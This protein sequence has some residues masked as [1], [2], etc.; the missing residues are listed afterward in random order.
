MHSLN[1]DLP[2]PVDSLLEES[3]PYSPGSVLSGR[4]P[5]LEKWS[6]SWAPL[7]EI[8]SAE[9]FLQALRSR[10]ISSARGY[11]EKD[12]TLLTRLGIDKNI[13]IAS[14]DITNR[15][16]SELF[17]LIDIGVIDAIDIYE[18]VVK[19]GSE[20]TIIRYYRR[21]PGILTEDD[22][23]STLGRIPGFIKRAAFDISSMNEKPARTRKSRVK[24]ETV[25]RIV[26]SSPRMQALI[27]L[28]EVMN[29]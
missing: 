14:F 5:Y 10:N 16:V 6:K 26:E 21:F 27:A 17:V 28:H 8:L 25:K 4:S 12:P 19:C 1:K 3:P 20:K 23:V 9:P 15:T 29:S 2:D 11:L 13:F 18:Y 7:S 24:I 22:L